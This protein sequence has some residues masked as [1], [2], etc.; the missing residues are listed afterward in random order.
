MKSSRA[1]ATSQKPRPG[2]AAP[3]Y[4]NPESPGPDETPLKDIG[5][6]LRYESEAWW[7][8]PPMLS[9]ETLSSY[10]KLKEAR[11]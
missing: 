1:L 3:E 9:P 11:L 2:M 6:V 5:E 7:L 8:Q 10:L 4:L